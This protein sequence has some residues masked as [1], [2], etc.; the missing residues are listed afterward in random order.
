VYRMVSTAATSHPSSGFT[1][2]LIGTFKRPS[3][4][5]VPG[6]GASL[7]V[8]TYRVGTRPLMTRVFG[9]LCLVNGILW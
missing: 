9:G 3:V 4:I 2:L 1:S 7:E 8:D 5:I 6:N